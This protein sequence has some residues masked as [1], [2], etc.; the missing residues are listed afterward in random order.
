MSRCSYCNN[1]SSTDTMVLN[2]WNGAGK[3]KVTF[4]YCSEECK[5][6]IVKFADYANKNSKKFLIFVSLDLLSLI[7]L[8]VMS[9]AFNDK[10]D[11]LFAFFVPI[12]FLGIILFKYPFATPFTN[13]KLGLKKSI[14]ILKIIGISLSVVGLSLIFLNIIL[15]YVSL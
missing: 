7:L 14:S 2:T 10:K 4:Q 5:D 11:L 8:L 13:T 12:L 9:I 15:T 1:E 6:Q 3:E